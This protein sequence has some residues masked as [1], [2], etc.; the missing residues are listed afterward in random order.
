MVEDMKQ[1]Q[2]LVKKELKHLGQKKA[3]KKEQLK[4]VKI[5]MKYQ[6]LIQKLKDLQLMMEKNSW[7]RF[8]Y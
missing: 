1:I 2:I 8:L 4:N 5:I 7:A 6:N 3:N